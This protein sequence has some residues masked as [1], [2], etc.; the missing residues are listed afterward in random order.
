VVHRLCIVGLGLM[1]GAVGLAVRKAGAATRVTGVADQPATIEKAKAIGAVDEA[2]LDLAAAVREADFIVLATPVRFIP[3]IARAVLLHVRDDAV[4]TDIGSSK[5]SVVAAVDDLIAKSK[6]PVFFVGSH[7]ISGS[8]KSGIECAGEVVLAGATCAITP[9]TTTNND[10]YRRVEEFWKALGMKTVRLSPDDHDATLAR[11][12]HLPHLISYLLLN[13]QTPRSLQLSGPGLRDTTRLAGSDP[14][15]WVD[16]VAQN[17]G[18]LTRVFKDFGQ[19]IVALAEE[20][21]ALTRPGTPGAESA[22]ERLFRT[23]AD[24]HT[25]YEAHYLGAGKRRTKAEVSGDED[26]SEEEDEKLE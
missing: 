9:T 22:R 14:A 20:L 21:E 12:S 18:E 4:L 15:L 23:M 1:G 26:G 2:T 6:K 10:A 25:R 16:I 7:P 3:E 24:A 13:A 19:E 17:A 11:S 8:E 5:V